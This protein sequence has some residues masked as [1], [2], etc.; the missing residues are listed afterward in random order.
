MDHDKAGVS[1]IYYKK[2][3]EGKVGDFVVSGEG[4]WVVGYEVD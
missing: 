2:E 3:M 4:N 1:F